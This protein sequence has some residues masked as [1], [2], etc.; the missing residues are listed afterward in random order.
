[1]RVHSLCLSILVFSM[2]LPAMGLEPGPP[3]AVSPSGVD[4][5]ITSLPAK[6]VH[7]DRDDDLH[8]VWI[9]STDGGSEVFYYKYNNESRRWSQGTALTQGSGAISASIDGTYDGELHCVWEDSGAVYHRVWNT[10]SEVWEPALLV[11]EMASDPSVLCDKGRN[12]HVIW[13]Q[14]IN[15]SQSSPRYLCHRY[16]ESDGDWSE[17]YTVTPTNAYADQPAASLDEANGLHVAYKMEFDTSK[18][19]DIYYSYRRAGREWEP[20][21]MIFDVTDGEVG[22]PAI[23]AGENSY[24][25]VVWDQE[26]GS[27]S[28]IFLRQWTSSWED[29]MQLTNSTGSAADPA[30]EIDSNSNLHLVWEDSRADPTGQDCELY[31]KRRWPLG[32]WT[33]AQRI[34][35]NPN[36]AEGRSP[37]S[38][39]VSPRDEDIHVM[40]SAVQ[41][42]SRVFHFIWPSQE[43]RYVIRTAS[44]ARTDVSGVDARPFVSPEGEEKLREAKAA[45][46]AGIDALRRFEVEEAEGNF[47]RCRDLIDEGYLLDEE[48]K[49]DLGKRMG[50]TMALVGIIGGAVVIVVWRL[51]RARDIEA[52]GSQESG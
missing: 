1:M 47:E 14:A 25:Y 5:R 17:T 15:S 24:S 11:S 21:Q 3:V 42:Q 22:R 36:P 28:Q 38:L 50:S 18:P 51:L 29:P 23:A 8:A 33:D 32:I 9:Q 19:P 37:P 30:V 31:Y 6:C 7:V 34:T 27:G 49:E 12:T 26:V 39:E 43:S 20:Y 52:Y 2:A 41:E 40:W 45:Y 16:V 46:E 13:L 4:A 44:R 48:Y 10:T 35:I